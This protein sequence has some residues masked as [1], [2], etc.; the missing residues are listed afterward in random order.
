MVMELGENARWY[1]RIAINRGIMTTEE[2]IALAEETLEKLDADSP[3]RDSIEG[4]L[5]YNKQMLREMRQ[6]IPPELLP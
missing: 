6:Y 2:S 1:V 5:A 3:V 4:M